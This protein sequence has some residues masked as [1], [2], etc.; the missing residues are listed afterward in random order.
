MALNG[1]VCAT[2]LEATAS[3]PSSINAMLAAPCQCRP[4]QSFPA[5]MTTLDNEKPSMAR[6]TTN[7]PKCV[8]LPTANTRMMAI[9]RAIM[10]PAINPTARK[11]ASR[12]ASSE[13]ALWRGDEATAA[14][15]FF[16]IAMAVHPP[17]LLCVPTTCAPSS[18]V[19]GTKGT[20]L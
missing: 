20:T 1:S 12:G 11:C 17:Q 8:Q 16:Q 7:E 15:Q 18:L 4:N 9:C 5:K 10:A 2:K 3:G 6:L 14:M 19:K 13:V